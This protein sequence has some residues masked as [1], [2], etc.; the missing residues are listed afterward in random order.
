MRLNGGQTLACVLNS[1]VRQISGS[2][3]FS[4]SAN[5][6]NVHVVGR[7]VKLSSHGLR[8][9]NIRFVRMY[10]SV[11]MDILYI[12]LLGNHQVAS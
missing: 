1:E 4:G 8:Y 3:M 7:P 10:A 9:T 5:L 6:K 2:V 12:H 11:P